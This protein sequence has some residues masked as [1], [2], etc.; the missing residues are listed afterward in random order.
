MEQNVRCNDEREENVEQQIEFCTDK[1]NKMTEK[2][3]CQGLA[4]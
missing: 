1:Y 4:F 2:R 3:I